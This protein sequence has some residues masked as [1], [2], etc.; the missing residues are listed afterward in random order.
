MQN[1]T[2]LKT[3]QKRQKFV[4]IKKPTNHLK[5]STLKV[6]TPSLLTKIIDLEGEQETNSIGYYW[7]SRTKVKEADWHYK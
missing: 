4:P 2:P 5:I 6:R 3:F 1:P 7:W